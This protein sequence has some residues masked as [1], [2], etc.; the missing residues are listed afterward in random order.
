MEISFL[1]SGDEL[2]TLISVNSEITKAGQHFITNAL[3]GSEICDL[4]SLADKNLAKSINDELEIEP[5]VRM[6]AD[7]LA[8]ADSS[9][10]KDDSWDIKSELINL[11]CQKYPYRDGYWKVTPVEEK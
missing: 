5:V 1:L 4:L 11:K 10:L 8:H 3:E 7:A 6:I 2:L 9:E